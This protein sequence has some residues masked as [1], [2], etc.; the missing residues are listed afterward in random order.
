MTG[1]DIRSDFR[2][3][4]EL[5]H[6][7]KVLLGKK[8]TS[9]GQ[10]NVIDSYNESTPWITGC[11]FLASGHAVLCENNNKKMKLLDKVLVLGESLKLDS[12]PWDVSV[13]DDNN[14]IITLPDTKQLQYI[15]VFPQLKTGRTVQ[16]GKICRGIEVFGDEIYTTQYD[17]LS[18]GAVQVLD[19]NG[20]MKR[21]LQSSFNFDRPDYIT[22]STSGK[23]I[24]VSDGVNSTARITCMTADGNLV[25]QYKDG[26]LV[27]PFA[28]YVD[29]EDNILVCD[30]VSNCVHVIIANGK[31]YGTLLTS[32][33]GISYPHS[34]AY[35]ETDDTLLVGCSG[36]DNIFT[37]KLV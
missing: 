9:Q 36:R 16:L 30:S 4:V 11:T 31:K 1:N 17:D 14:I 10:V 37:Y 35:R 26:E 20:N 33:D 19:L 15:Q 22:V 6:K 29:A 3:K 2:G 5:K 12:K 18:Q 25:Y 28:M 21:K 32:S 34:I 27:M 8:A 24:F 23:K 7:R 13:V